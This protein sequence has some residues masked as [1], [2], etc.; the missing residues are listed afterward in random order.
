MF[1][2]MRRFKQQ[3]TNE[4]C[5]E[6]LKNQKRGVLSLVGDDG[7]PYGLPI[8][9]LYCEESGTVCFHGSKEGHKTD[10][11]KNCDKASFCV[12]DEGYKNDGEWYLNFRSVIVFGRIKIINDHDRALDIC[13]RLMYKFIDDREFTENEIKK[14]GNNVQ[15]L[16]LT[17]EHITGKR[18]K[19]K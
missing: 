1:R 17:A 19:E 9:Y 12:Y 4:E 3:L 7:Y 11:I 14:H 10:A 8:N 6:I 15:C 16:E 5:I 2:K 13:R 18:I